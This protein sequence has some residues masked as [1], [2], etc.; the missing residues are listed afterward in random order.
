MSNHL[1]FYEDLTAFSKFEDL[2]EETQFKVVPKD[3]YVIISTVVD[4][5][6]AISE[7]RYKDVNN[8]GVASIASIKNGLGGKDFPY[9]FKG[10]GSSAVIP[11]TY[12]DQ[13]KDEL[14]ALRGIAKTEFELDLRVCIV[15]I[16]KALTPV[17]EIRVG[18]FELTNRNFMSMF[19]GGGMA[20][21]DRIVQNDVSY[22]LEERS[23]TST[24]LKHLS[25]RWKPI[26]SRNGQMLCLLVQ[27]QSETHPEIY[28]DFLNEFNSII[29]EHE[30]SRP[31]N[32]QTMSYKNP[33]KNVVDETRYG[34]NTWFK[35]KRGVTA[36]WQSLFFLIPAFRNFVFRKY[37]ND[38]DANTD[39]RKFDD[40]L[41]MLVDC[42]NKQAEEIEQLCEKFYKNNQVFYG[43]HSSKNAV[44]TCF[45]E[46]LF[47]AKH[48]HFLDGENG[49]YAMAAIP[50]RAQIKL[51]V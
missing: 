15:P 37:L 35:V 11:P 2:C 47:K 26:Q 45:V 33:L 20:K 22:D 29:P 44:M 3:W 32:H 23:S 40:M 42:T 5:E 9:T 43:I 31:V 14:H 4:S 12:I 7:G 19:K 25:C 39:Y 28:Q 34:Q 13:V 21:I 30:S 8:L 41:K 48:M 10:N 51:A 38:M 27:A 17:E 24:N 46:D 50:L 36:A 6:E 49:G 18:K 1:D 16:A